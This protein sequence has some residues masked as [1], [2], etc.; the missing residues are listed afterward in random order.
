MIALAFL[1]LA[2]FAAPE[3]PIHEQIRASLAAG[4]TALQ[5]SRWRAASEAYARVLPRLVPLLQAPATALMT[6]KAVAR[7]AAARPKV[8]R[9]AMGVRE[10][11]QA[12]AP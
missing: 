12:R 4:E 5:A 7:M 9:C 11:S 6:A 10:R 8:R 3:T 1:A 2:A